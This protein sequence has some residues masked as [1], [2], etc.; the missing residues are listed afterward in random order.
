MSI[1]KP[2]RL[3]KAASY[4]NVSRE[5]IVKYLTAVGFDILDN[6]NSKIDEAMNEWLEDKYS[7]D[8]ILKEESFPGQAQ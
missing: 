7:E 3:A 6:P 1:V 4:Y 5:E 8:R 2:T